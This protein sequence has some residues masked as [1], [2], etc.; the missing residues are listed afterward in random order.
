MGLEEFEKSDFPQNP[1]P[2]ISNK[3]HL[4]KEK[5]KIIEVSDFFIER[6]NVEVELLYIVYYGSY[7]DYGIKKEILKVYSLIHISL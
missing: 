6:L 5:Q 4:E 2:L 1:N 7:G 3:N